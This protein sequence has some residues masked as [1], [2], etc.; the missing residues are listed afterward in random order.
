[1]KKLIFA[2]FKMYQNTKKEID[3]YL[4]ELIEKKK[5]L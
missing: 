1:M 3:N 2:N 5:T 4:N